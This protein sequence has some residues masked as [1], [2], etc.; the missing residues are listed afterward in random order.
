M[1]VPFQKT[2]VSFASGSGSCVGY[3]YHR[4]GE[5]QPCVVMG[6][7][8]GGVQDTPLLVIAAQAF[9][10]VGICALTFDYRG[11]G[12]SPGEPR[13]VIRIKDQLQ[14]FH[15]AIWYARS[16]PEIDP[17][18]IAAWGISLGGGHVL[19]VGADDPRLKAVV[20]QNPFN[21]FPRQVKGG[22]RSLTRRLLGPMFV[23]AVRGWLRLSPRYI[24][25]VGELNEQAVSPTPQ[26]HRAIK[27]LRSPNWKNQVAPRGLF[28]LMGYQPGRAAAHLAM[29]MLVCIGAGDRESQGDTE[30][31]LA[32]DAPKGEL[33]EYP[34]SQLDFYTSGLR[35]RVI[36]DQLAFL[37]KYLLD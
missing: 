22:V 6:A 10:S 29:P 9:A 3:L 14:D 17:Q 12:E 20:A 18:R 5:R 13:H 24:Q 37:K 28:Q 32:A 11:F 23:D 33:I 7:G 27:A 4:P 8:L 36:A 25:V 26:A 34:G 21:G 1:D 16:Q 2:R 19:C 15:A 31:Q 35:Q 30:S